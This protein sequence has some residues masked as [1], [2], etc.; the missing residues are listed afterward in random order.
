[1]G[2]G[3]LSVN[4]AGV[5]RTV[6]PKE[7]YLDGRINLASYL[8]YAL[9]VSLPL[10]IAASH[11]ALAG[12]ILLMGYRFWVGREP[13]IRTALDRAVLIYL[14]VILA[15]AVLGVNPG[16]SLVRMGAFWHIAL[17]WIVVNTVSSQTLA[18]RLIFTLIAVGSVNALYGILQ[19]V[20]GGL[21]LFSFGGAPRI[22]RDKDMVRASGVFDHYMTFSGQMLMLASLGCGLLLFWAKGLG[23]WAVVSAV[24]L[25]IGGVITSWTRN[26][27]LGLIAAVL[28]MAGF[29]NRLALILSGVILIVVV[30]VLLISSSG[31]RERA[32]SIVAVKSDVSITDRFKTWRTAL[33]MI[34][35]RPLLGVG[36]GNFRSEMEHYRKPDGPR[37]H[38]HAHNTLL[39]VAAENGLIGLSAYVLIW[40]IFFREMI[41]G[42]K[43]VRAPFSR[44]VSVGVIGAIVGF[45]VA[46]LFEYNLGDSE[47]A[48]MM[49]F[50]V[51][52]GL[53]ARA[54]R[55]EYTASGESGVVR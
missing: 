16:R 53:A 12:L 37:S 43:S 36:T 45:H 4:I 46:G 42:L 15:S 3:G 38:S 7:K 27:W 25:F 35:H 23:S 6:P 28:V 24:V 39:E 30:S 48:I 47:V 1:V 55:F 8:L 18:R 49:W 54:G 51:G 29:K 19:H 50:L 14:L 21:D 13:V 44:G 22:L 33:E 2:F 9:V 10:S 52:L 11:I 26:A 41:R 40:F 20:M 5:E 17:F 34:Q 31:L 32:V